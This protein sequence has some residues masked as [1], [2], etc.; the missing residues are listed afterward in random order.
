MCQLSDKFYA[1]VR[2]LAGDGPI[3]VRLMSAYCEN[4]ES[5]S[6]DDIP[7][8]IRQRFELLRRAM[9]FVKPNFSESVVFASVRKMSA[10]DATRHAA[11]IVAMFSELVRVKSTGERIRLLAAADKNNTAGRLTSPPHSILN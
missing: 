9:H 1:A 10:A 2:T 3:K 4:L 7:E 5:L 11:H 8:S 6:E